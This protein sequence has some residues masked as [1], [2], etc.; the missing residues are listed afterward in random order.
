ME[1]KMYFKNA[2]IYTQT[3]YKDVNE[4]LESLGIST[5]NEYEL[6]QIA[7]FYDS[8]VSWNEEEKGETGIKLNNG[9]RFVIPYSYQDFSKFIESIINAD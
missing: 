1:N 9:D 5:N 8:L 6:M 2:I 7:F 3:Y 4:E